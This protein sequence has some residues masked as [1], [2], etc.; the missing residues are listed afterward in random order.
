MAPKFVLA[1]A[2]AGVATAAALPRGISDI[3]IVGGEPAQEGD[4]PFIVSLQQGG[5]HFCGGTLI[6]SNKVVT[7]AHCS[8]GQDPASVSVRAGS[9]SWSSGGVE[10]KVD[11]ITVHPDYDAQTID[12][13]V[14]VWTLADAIEEGDGV[15]FGSLPQQGSDLSGNATVTVAGWGA[16]E[17]GD[18]Q[19]PDELM[20]VSVPVTDRATCSSQYGAG[21]ITENMV[22]A[23]LDEGGKDACQGDS[24]G[25]LVD[26]Q[27]TLVG[28]VSWGQGCAQAGFSGVYA[29]VGSF[30]EWIGQQ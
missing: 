15:S 17:Q 2:F 9:L 7:A 29:R 28:V 16:L 11:S 8:E 27:G 1:A 24:G 12:N 6:G 19:L 20:K 3:L 4:F 13:D 5:S 26:E 30:V 23:G 22:C 25:P 21:K 18:P 14:A 10:A